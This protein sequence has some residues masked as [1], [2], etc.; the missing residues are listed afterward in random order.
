[1]IRCY[2]LAVKYWFW[3]YRWSDALYFAR[4]ITMFKRDNRF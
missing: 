2:L 1:M 4:M 3:G